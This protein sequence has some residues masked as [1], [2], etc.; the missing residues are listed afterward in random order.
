MNY[1]SAIVVAAGLIAGALLFNGQA[2]S[3]TS[4]GELCEYP[5]HHAEPTSRSM[6]HRYSYRT[7]V[8]LLDQWQQPTPGASLQP[9][10]SDRVT[11]TE[12]Y[13]EVAAAGR[14]SV[15][16]AEPKWLRRARDPSTRVGRRADAALRA[17]PDPASDSISSR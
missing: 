10:V 11:G 2:I 1:P 7:G 8:V 6:A 15:A 9:V 4:A 5:Q 3:Q 17:G 16:A 14:R 12:E 13:D